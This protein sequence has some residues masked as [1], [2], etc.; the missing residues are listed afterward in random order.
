VLHARMRVGQKGVTHFAGTH[1]WAA[2][3]GHAADSVHMSL[4][5]R[6]DSLHCAA[7]HYVNAHSGNTAVNA[8]GNSFS[9]AAQSRAFENSRRT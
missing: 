8:I 9:T 6:K 1:R 4:K 3:R 5:R 2:P 7:L